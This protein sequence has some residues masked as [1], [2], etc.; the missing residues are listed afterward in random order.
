MKTPRLYAD[1]FGHAVGEV[2]LTER[3]H[4]Y[5]ARVLRAKTSQSIEL[6]DG[7]GRSCQAIIKNI[8]KR[9]TI[10]EILNVT[11]HKD[12]RLPVTLGL[13]LI[14]SDRF[15]WALQKVT[16]LGVN[17][18]QP[19]ITKF[20]DS[21]PNASRLKKKWRHWQEILVNA[22]EQSENNWLPEL[23]KPSYLHEL[24]LPQQVVMAHPGG[25]F[26]YIDTAKESLLLI[27]PEGGFSDD[28][29]NSLV[30]NQVKPMSLGPTI[31]RA[32]TAAIVGLTLLGHQYGHY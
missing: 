22:C 9:K 1:G 7:E 13:A 8:S 31:L 15:D 16:E 11:E 5:L 17:A 6:F 20:T 2:I 10:A 25:E 28:E 30:K 23:R 12:R 32:E 19:I 26:A 4:H 21:P 18:I 24:V 3:N 29:V 14:K 27:G